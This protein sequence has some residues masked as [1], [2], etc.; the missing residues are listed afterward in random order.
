MLGIVLAELGFDVTDENDCD[1]IVEY[2]GQQ[3]LYITD[4][5]NG[6]TEKTDMWHVT[7]ILA[8]NGIKHGSLPDAAL[9]YICL[10]YTSA[11]LF[12]FQGTAKG[13]IPCPEFS[14]FTYSHWDRANAHPKSQKN[15][16]KFF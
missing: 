8:L 3:E 4:N 1:L 13:E 15:L 9:P 6:K 12:N 10:L 7:A 11:C 5:R 2:E 14:P 16:K